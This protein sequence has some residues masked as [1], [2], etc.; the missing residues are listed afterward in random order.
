[1]RRR[2]L[3]QLPSSSS[4]RAQRERSLP[5]PLAALL[6][7]SLRCGAG[8]EGGEEVGGGEERGGEE[9]GDGGEEPEAEEEDSAL[10]EV[11]DRAPWELD[12]LL[13]RVEAEAASAQERALRE[14]EPG[15]EAAEFDH[16]AERERPEAH[17]L[18]QLRRPLA[19]P[20][21]LQPLGV[22]RVPLVH[23]P[24]Q[25]LR[26]DVERRPAQTL[27]ARSAVLHDVVARAFAQLMHCSAWHP[28]M[29][30]DWM[31]W[32]EK[33]L[34]A[35]VFARRAVLS[36][37]T[38]HVGLLASLQNDPQRRKRRHGITVFNVSH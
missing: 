27:D 24:P 34:E 14:L 4:L 38:T 19:A 23:V 2:K 11:G 28:D 21:E 36:Q 10:V 17:R 25:K 32:C 13:G 9:E 15:G 5:L 6:P 30:S 3:G 16:D 18:A 20:A 33:K 37:K 1:M 35:L 29:P 26:L 8:V 22:Q 7:A 12:G 31:Q